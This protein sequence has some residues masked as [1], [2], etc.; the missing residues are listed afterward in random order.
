M[1]KLLILSILSITLVS[2]NEKTPEDRLELVSELGTLIHRSLPDYNSSSYES[3]I[4]FQE[5]DSTLI[6]AESDGYDV[7]RIKR[8]KNLKV[9]INE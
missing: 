3:F 5:S 1:K 9:T 6:Y 4:L 2:C 7:K 8:L